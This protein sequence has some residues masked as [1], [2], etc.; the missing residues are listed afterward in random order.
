MMMSTSVG[1]DVLVMTDCP[2]RIDCDSSTQ[3]GSGAADDDDVSVSL[4]LRLQAEEHAY[5]QTWG[6]GWFDATSRTHEGNEHCPDDEESLALAIRLQQEDDEA[7]LRATLGL[8]ENEDLPGSPSNY[9]HE[10][11]LRLADTVGTVSRGASSQVV[12]GLVRFTV[13]EAH[14]SEKAILGEQVCILP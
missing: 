11:L 5:A 14:A 8:D 7:Q 12:D 10:Q 9:T 2:E 13:A 6:A 1:S 4:A 3:L